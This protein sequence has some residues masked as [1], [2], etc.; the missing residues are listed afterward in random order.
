[1]RPPETEPS[2]P[3]GWRR[4]IALEPFRH[5]RWELLVMRFFFAILVWDTQTG[6]IAHWQDPPRAVRAMVEN[7]QTFDIRYQSQPHPNGL[8][9]F[10]DFSFLSRDEIEKPLRYGMGV[11]LLLYVVGVPGV[12]ALLVPLFFSI[13]S[14][15]LNNS[16][17][18][19]GHTAQGL[20]L[21]LLA[22]WLASLVGWIRRMRGGGIA[23][24][25]LSIGRLE[26]DWGRQALAATYVVSAITKL[27]KSNGLWFIEAQFFPLHLVKNLEMRYYTSLDETVRRLD[28]LPEVMLQHPHWCQLLFGLALPLELFVFWGLR[29]RRLAAIFGIGLIAFHESV[30]Q[31]TMLSFIFNKAL[32]L[33]FFVCPWWWL[34]PSSWRRSPVQQLAD[35]T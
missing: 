26:M 31:L 34:R 23:V 27:I 15:T 12:V 8:G 13:G 20:H 16:Q 17:G 21:M 9:H 5:A 2:V 7:A 29:N 11:S 35:S 19:I 6:W 22:V 24:N 10:V 14:A 28:W 30:T 3:A 32:L 18:S 4:W 25:R 33:V 1:M